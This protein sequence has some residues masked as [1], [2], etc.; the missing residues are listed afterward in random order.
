MARK[1]RTRQH[2]IADMSACHF[3]WRALQCGYSVERVL[4]DYGVDLVLYSYGP[5]GEI[6]NESVSVQLKAT[7]SPSFSD[8]GVSVLVRLDNRD[9]NAWSA[10]L[11]PVIL[12]L[13]NAVEDEAYWIHV[14]D[15]VRRNS[16]RIAVAGTTTV[17]IPLTDRLDVVAIREFAERKNA[18]YRRIKAVLENLL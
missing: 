17:R 18:E 7:D 2:I 8:D 9:L 10:N 15:Y 16:V 6:E 5:S 4:H 1:R 14:Q 11:M 13:Y 12:L 3:E